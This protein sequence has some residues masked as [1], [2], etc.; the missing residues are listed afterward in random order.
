M[1]AD[2]QLPDLTAFSL[3]VT[4]YIAE[5]KVDDF[6][7]AMRPCFEAV[8]AEPELLYFELFQDPASPGK[9]SWVE[10]WDASPQWLMDVGDVLSQDEFIQ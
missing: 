8:S 3:H 10:N 6:F 1:A 7:A 9:I 5:D 4:V 2:L